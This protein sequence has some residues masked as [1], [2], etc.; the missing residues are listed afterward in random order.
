MQEKN[1]PGELS[2]II[3]QRRSV[4]QFTERVITEEEELVLIQSAMAAP[5]ATNSRPLR[6]ISIQSDQAREELQKMLE[7]GKE[8]LSALLASKKDRKAF[9]RHRVLWHFTLPMLTA[10]LLWAVY[11][12]VHPPEPMDAAMEE[13]TQMKSRQQYNMMLSLG[14]SLQN[15]SLKAVEMGLGSC[16][17]TAPIRFLHAAKTEK[18][19]AAFMAFGEPAQIPSPPAQNTIESI[20]QR[21]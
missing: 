9:Q 1:I 17:Y 2:R 6:I 20:Y 7:Q 10:P 14:A 16:I 5:S 12:E 3:H 4:R 13:L 15:A 8:V 18:I 19:P 21:K 11:G